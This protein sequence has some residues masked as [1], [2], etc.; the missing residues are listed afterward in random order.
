MSNEFRRA[1]GGG[2]GASSAK[3]DG[4]R[5]ASNYNDVHIQVSE[6]LMQFEE[7]NQQQEL[8]DYRPMGVVGYVRLTVLLL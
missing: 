6:T 2:G 5:R 7:Q 1:A 4:S 3:R 8:N